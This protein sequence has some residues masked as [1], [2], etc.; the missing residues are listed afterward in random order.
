MKNIYLIR[1]GEA[2]DDINKTYG[3]WADDP[4]TPKGE[5]LAEE[6]AKELSKLGIKT[7][8]SSSLKRAQKTA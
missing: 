6:L 3:G 8:Y 4:L 2:L 7:I 1:H 5:K